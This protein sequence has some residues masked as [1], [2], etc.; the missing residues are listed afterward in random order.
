MSVCRAG[1]SLISGHDG[2]SERRAMTAAQV[3]YSTAR[4]EEVT[5]SFVRGPAARQAD[6]QMNVVPHLNS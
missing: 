4:G 6:F 2:T 5:P 3:E 1:V